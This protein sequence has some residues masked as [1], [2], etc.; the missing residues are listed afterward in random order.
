MVEMKYIE[1]FIFFNNIYKN[2]LRGIIY[3]RYL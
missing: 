3:Q 2:T 1:V